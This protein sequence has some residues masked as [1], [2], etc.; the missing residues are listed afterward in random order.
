[1]GERRPKTGAREDRGYK[2]LLRSVIERRPS[3]LPRAAGDGARQAQELRVAAS[4]NPSYT[5][6]RPATDL[7][8]ICEI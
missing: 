8:T 5:V 7:T 3:C 6:T 4:T 2:T 1:M